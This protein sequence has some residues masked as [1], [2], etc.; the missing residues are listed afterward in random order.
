[1][2]ILNF[3]KVIFVT[4]AFMAVGPSLILL[5]KH[6]MNEMDFP[7][8]MFISGI[9]VLFSGIFANILVSAGFVTLDNKQSMQGVNFYKRVL[10]IAI[11]AAGALAFGNYVYLLLDVGL[12]QM[13]K[14]FTPVLV[15]FGTFM[16]GIE[17]PDRYVIFAIFLICFGT[18]VTCSYSPSASI[19]GLFVMFLT[20]SFEAIR[21]VR[22]CSL[23]KLI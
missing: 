17:T 23:V 3:V 22:I 13:L 21:M 5:N 1:M 12:I 2:S 16:I 8:P 7:F 19:L 20:S 11:S 10:P 18:T 9:G 4:L 14:N 15:M 6:I